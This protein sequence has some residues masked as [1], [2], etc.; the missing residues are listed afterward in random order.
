MST[1]SKG[2]ENTKKSEQKLTGAKMTTTAARGG[3]AVGVGED[4]V[5][6]VIP[7]T[8]QIAARFQRE[9]GKLRKG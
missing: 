5:V 2:R 4:E 1:S 3:A 9:V 6:A 8:K 7:A